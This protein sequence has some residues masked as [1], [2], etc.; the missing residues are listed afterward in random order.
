M[1]RRWGISIPWSSLPK[2]IC[3]IC[4]GIV[5]P[6]AGRAKKRRWPRRLANHSRAP[7]LAETASVVVV[8]SNL[9]TYGIAE[10]RR[11]SETAGGRAS[12]PQPYPWPAS[13]HLDAGTLLFQLGLDRRRLVLR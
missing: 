2:E 5:H 8:R 11:A 7:G 9:I 3:L 12:S 4:S 13:L 1:S 10:V 6:H